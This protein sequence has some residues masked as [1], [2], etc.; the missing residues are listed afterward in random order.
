MNIVLNVLNLMHVQ[1]LNR[2]IYSSQLRQK[3]RIGEQYLLIRY[4]SY[5][6]IDQQGN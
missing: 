1:S 5:L 3:K 6:A 4:T 2:S